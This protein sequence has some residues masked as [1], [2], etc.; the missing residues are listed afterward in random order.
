M[1]RYTLYLFFLFCLFSS[2]SFAQKPLN[3]AYQDALHEFEQQNYG[4][5][6]RILDYIL[7][8]DNTFAEAYFLQGQ[9]H[10]IHQDDR[11][12]IEAYQH[13]NQ[14]NNDTP[15]GFVKVAEIYKKHHYQNLV[16]QTLEEGLK[17]YPH[18]AMMLY[19]KATYLYEHGELDSAYLYLTKCIDN[20]YNFDK[21]Y[22]DRGV[23]LHC[24]EKDELATKDF[25]V[26]ILINPQPI[27]YLNQGVNFYVIGQYSKAI[28]AYSQVIRLDSQNVYAYNLRG[29][30]YME[31][32]NDMEATAD[33]LSAIAI[34]QEYSYPYNN[35]ANVLVGKKDYSKAI[36]LYNT[37][38]ELDNECPE[39]YFNRG[40]IKEITS[41]HLEN[42][43]KDWQRA[44]EL[45]MPR[46][47]E[48][49][50]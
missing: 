23:I 3:I 47:V 44:V 25:A 8:I 48:Y 2:F 49:C 12:A 37:A 42:A 40:N 9:L 5:T 43:C 11:A 34:D 6:Q 41:E 36:A 14:Y 28:N 27:Y 30:A 38:L 15:K 13:F 45:G 24:Q 19:S 20:D 22:N 50:P 26:A 46:V 31:Q 10:E 32:G 4:Q 16:L 18:S 33:F 35:L 29:V 21:A 39:I 17:R 1:K 7:R